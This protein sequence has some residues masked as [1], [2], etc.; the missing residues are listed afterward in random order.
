MN[1]P[2][3]QGICMRKT[4]YLIS[5]VMVFALL[6]TSCNFLKKASLS[7]KCEV[8]SDIEMAYTDKSEMSVDINVFKRTVAGFLNYLDAG[9]KEGLKKLLSDTLLSRDGVE[10]ELDELFEGFKGHIIETTYIASDTYAGMPGSYE[11]NFYVTTDKE[12][13]YI[14]LVVISEDS[15]GGELIGINQIQIM[16]LDKRYEVEI[17][18]SEFWDFIDSHPEGGK[19]GDHYN[20]TYNF[21]DGEVKTV[22]VDRL[23]GVDC[24]ILTSFGN[25]EGYT[26]INTL[27]KPNDCYV[28][29]LTGTTDSISAEELKKKD[30]SDLESVNEVFGELEPYAMPDETYYH[31]NDFR[32]YN[33]SDRNSNE[34]AYVYYGSDKT[35]PRVRIFNLD[36]IFADQEW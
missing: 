16:T 24:F 22:K 32:F 14:N 13:Y 9:D 7:Q 20:L 33:L 19:K 26:R 3:D 11:D 28:W 25:S 36:K 35:V 30:F 10:D 27:V 5:I 8:Y 4:V 6:I 21:K 2:I 18:K 17:D 34:K 23:I 31:D 29:K 1:D 12:N 15:I